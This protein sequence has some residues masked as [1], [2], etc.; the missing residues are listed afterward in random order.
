MSVQRDEKSFFESKGFGKTMGFG[1][2][3]ALIVID[4][5]RAFTEYEDPL[6]VLAADLDRELIETDKLLKQA[7][8]QGIPVIFTTVAY[9]DKDLRDAGTWRLK[10]S[11]VVTLEAGTR[12]CEID[13][14]LDYRETEDTLL[15]KN[16]ASAFFGTD[17]VSR[18]VSR[19][20]D[21]VIL[22]GCTTSGCIRASAVDA[23]SYGFRPI[24]AL[25]AVGDRS[26]AAHEQ[27]LFDLQAKYAD[28]VPIDEILSYMTSAV[29]AG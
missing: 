26:P 13:P 8:V 18:L 6:M 22:A 21:T 24:V 14:R 27:S 12:G 28:V 10:Q 15:Y 9:R 19:G 23:V 11:G 16:Y 1:Q 3:P 29:T 17:L 25:E 7:H 20:I 5:I 2:K 4:M